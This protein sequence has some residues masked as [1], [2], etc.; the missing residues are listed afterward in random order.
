MD[1][2]RRFILGGLATLVAAR[3]L[4]AA[5]DIPTLWADGA[6]DD[7]PALQAWIDGH[8]IRFRP[9]ARAA[10]SGDRL[11]VKDA[12][13]MLGDTLHM[14]RSGRPLLLHGGR[15]RTMP[16]FNAGCMIKF[17]ASGSSPMPV[18]GLIFDARGIYA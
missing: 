14:K 17:D 12:E 13:I 18:G 15:A 16:G 1:L 2:T 10:H 8:A 7:Q 6:H 4:V 9:G 3:P 5:A 11:L